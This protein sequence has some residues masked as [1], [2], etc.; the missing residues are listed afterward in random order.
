M[1]IKPLFDSEDFA[2]IGSADNALVVWCRK[3]DRE[4][5][6]TIVYPPVSLQAFCDQCVQRKSFR[7]VNATVVEST[8]FRA[9]G[10]GA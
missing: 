6:V 9:P 8:T 4:A 7:L 1:S 5:A 10:S 2:F 3:C